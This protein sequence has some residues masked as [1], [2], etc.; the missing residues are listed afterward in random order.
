MCESRMGGHVLRSSLW[1]SVAGCSWWDLSCPGRH[2]RIKLV[3][4]LKRAGLAVV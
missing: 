4:D 2:F 3:R 1:Q